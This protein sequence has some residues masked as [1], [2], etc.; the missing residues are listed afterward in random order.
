MIP[1][2]DLAAATSFAKQNPMAAFSILVVLFLG[3]YGFYWVTKTYP[4]ARN[5]LLLVVFFA[6]IGVGVWINWEMFKPQPSPVSQILAAVQSAQETIQ[7]Q[8]VDVLLLNKNDSP[9]PDDRLS[10]QELQ[11]DKC[12]YHGKVV[13]PGIAAMN[14]RV[15][16]DGTVTMLNVMI[17]LERNKENPNHFKAFVKVKEG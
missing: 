14:R 8:G 11:G 7:S 15:C 6:Y 17:P 5:K 4:K 1:V 13:R 16:P 3:V 12:I 2:V 9:K 10:F